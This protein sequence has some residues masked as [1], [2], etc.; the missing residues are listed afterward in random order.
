MN[1]RA[2]KGTKS[3]CRDYR[4]SPRR[5]TLCF[6]LPA[7]S[8][9]GFKAFLCILLC[10]HISALAAPRIV[11]V[12]NAGV[13]F[14]DNQN[15]VS[16][17]DAGFS[18]AVGNVSL[19]L[20]GDVFLLDPTAP[21]KKYVGGVSNCAVI[22]PKGSGASTL[23]HYRF[24]TD[25]K[26]GRVRQVIPYD[27][28]EGNETRLWPGGSWYDAAHHKAYLYYGLVKMTE[29]KGPFN[30]RS[31]GQCLAVADTTDPANLLFHRLRTK[32]GSGVW[33]PN[34]DK[35]P[36]FGFGVIADGPGRDGWLYVAGEHDHAAKMAR[37]RPDRI[38]DLDAY[39]YM[40]GSSAAPRWSKNVADAVDV[41]GFTDFPSELSVSYNRYLGGYLAVHSVLISEKMRFSLAPHP[42][43]PYKTIGEIGAPHLL[44]SSSFCY[45]GK[46]HPELS[47]QG[48]RVVYVTY[49]DSQRYW[50]QMF[51]VTLER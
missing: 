31:E 49:V 48:G 38:A 12:E 51:K 47:E 9:A 15:G 7:N 19:W 8:F 26:T 4:S 46:E 14:A 25:A 30:F 6:L 13:P 29:G 42:W 22:V 33:W 17:M 32:A 45:A 24:I 36:Q 2:T 3:P 35:L 44:F 16:G 21:T 41:E 37:V 43:G 23:R 50:L 39:E 34:R 10:I 28:A 5:R 20:F 1:S 27:G 11:K 18:L 40:A